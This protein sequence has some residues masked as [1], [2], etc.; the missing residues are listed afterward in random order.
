MGKLCN[1]FSTELW[2][3]NNADMNQFDPYIRTSSVNNEDLKQIILEKEK[4]E[5]SETVSNS[6]GWHSEM[7]LQNDKRFSALWDFIA[8][9]MKQIIRHNIDTNISKN[10]INDRDVDKIDIF[11][12]H[13]WA[14]VNRYRDYNKIH[15]HPSADWAGVYYIAGPKNSGDLQFYDPTPKQLLPDNQS[16]YLEP[17]A[18]GMLIFPYWLQHAVNPNKT[19]EPRISISFN[20][21]TKEKLNNES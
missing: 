17:F 6:G 5:V 16:F 2:Q 10:L 11:I 13:A 14:I 9:G 18:G 12:S 7:C 15:M 19:K 8:L 3:F 4:T 1:L 21:I 20:I